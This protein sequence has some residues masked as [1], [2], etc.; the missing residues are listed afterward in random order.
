MN[1]LKKKDVIYNKYYN[2]IG[3]VIDSFN[4]ESGDIRTDSDGVVYS[5]NCMKINS[6]DLLN[7]YID[8]GVDIAPSTLEIINKNKLL[9]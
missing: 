6:Y 3:I 4:D 1:N 2:S 8:N 7:R 5:G 9:K